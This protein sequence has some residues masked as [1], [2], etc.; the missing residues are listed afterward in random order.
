MGSKGGK[1][2]RGPNKARKNTADHINAWWN[3]PAADPY[4]AK[5]R[6]KDPRREIGPE[7]LEQP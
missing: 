3:S 7:I 4:R 6:K 5:K 1:A 2:G